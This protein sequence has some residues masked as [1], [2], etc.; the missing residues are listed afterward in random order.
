MSLV[1][2]DAVD[3]LSW[4]F[5]A[6]KLCGLNFMAKSP[7]ITRRQKSVHYIKLSYFAF[8]IVNFALGQILQIMYLPMAYT[9]DLIVFANVLAAVINMLGISIKIFSI[10][11]NRAEIWQM[12]KQWGQINTTILSPKSEK[13]VKKLLVG[14]KQFKTIKLSLTALT[15]FA[16]SIGPILRH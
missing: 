16:Y 8:M 11:R 14:F 6:L 2:V 1:K 15:V 5:T 12:L 13:E 9:E 3:L 4:S 10:L 7:G